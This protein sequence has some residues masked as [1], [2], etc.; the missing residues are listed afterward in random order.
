MVKLRASG[1]RLRASRI[2]NILAKLCIPGLGWPDFFS[3]GPNFIKNS[4]LRGPQKN[5]PYFF[6]DKDYIIDVNFGYFIHKCAINSLVVHP[7][8][9]T[10]AAENL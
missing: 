8:F 10:G 2:R 7:K 4:V 6:L 5:F 3:D 9:D 1:V